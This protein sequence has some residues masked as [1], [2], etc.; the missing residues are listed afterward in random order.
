MIGISGLGRAEQE[1]LQ[2]RTIFFLGEVMVGQV[3]HAIKMVLRIENADIP[4]SNMP[5]APDRIRRSV[6]QPGERSIGG[7]YPIIGRTVGP[8]DAEQFNVEIRLN[9]LELAENRLQVPKLGT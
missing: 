6:L 3:V 5:A 1:H 7:D 9:S 2:R 8:V 4:V